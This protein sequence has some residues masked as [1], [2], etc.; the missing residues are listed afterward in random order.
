[1]TYLGHC[2]EGRVH[3]DPVEFFGELSGMRSDQDEFGHRA[4]CVLRRRVNM[5]KVTATLM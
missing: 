3:Q 2:L 1:M 5:G 4:P